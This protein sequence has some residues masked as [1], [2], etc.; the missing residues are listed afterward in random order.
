MLRAF[1]KH[2]TRPPVVARFKLPEL[3][4]I[5][6]R[7]NKPQHTLF[8]L[9]A[10]SGVEAECRSNAMNHILRL[11]VSFAEQLLQMGCVRLQSSKQTPCSPSV[12]SNAPPV[13]EH[14]KPDTVAG[15]SES[16]CLSV[17][18]FK[19]LALT[20]GPHC[21]QCTSTC[22]WCNLVSTDY[23]LT[24]EAHKHAP[25][26][27]T[28]LCWLRPLCSSICI[29]NRRIDLSEARLAFSMLQDL[30]LRRHCSL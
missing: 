11:S 3:D 6:S 12:G 19:Y 29:C 1:E 8:A 18:H 25:W 2:C 22:S 16:I 20:S 13:H 23:S 15:S 27:S 4:Q 21:T 10:A 7:A 5:L 28:L 24:E 14:K 9:T 26:V 30:C 17:S